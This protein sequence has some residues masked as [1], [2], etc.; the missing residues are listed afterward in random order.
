VSHHYQYEETPYA[1]L[2]SDFKK[3]KKDIAFIES[4][5]SNLV[6]SSVPFPGSMLAAV[7][8]FTGVDG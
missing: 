7:W 8:R 3:I 1:N 4:G 2:E 6:E 5:N